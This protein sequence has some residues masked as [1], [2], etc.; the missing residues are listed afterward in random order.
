MAGPLSG[1]RVVDLTRALAGPYCSLLLGD[2]GADVIK[3]ELPGSGDETRQWGP[4]FVAGESSYFMSV[5]RNKRSATLDLKSADGVDVLKRLIQSADVLVENFRP[6]TMERLGLAYDDAHQLNPSL[7]YCSVSGFGQTGPRARQPAYDA[8]L[9]GMGGIQYLSGEAD[10]GPTRVGVPIADITAG[11]F[12]AYAVA[13]ALFWRERDPERRGQLID[14]SMLGGQVALLT[15]QAGRYFATDSAPSRIGN[16]HASIA[17]Y[18]MFR[19]ADGYVNV[20]AAN[21]PM[22]QRFCRALDLTAL[23]SDTRFGTNPDRVTN[24]AELSALIEAR[25][26]ELTQAEVIQRLEAAEVPVGP[27]YDLAQVFADPQSQ[28]LGMAVPTPHPKVPDLRTTG[29]P[30]RMSETNPEVRCPPPLLGEHTA[31]VLGELGYTGAEVER[32]TRPD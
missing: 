4:P 28:H 1:T 15:Y 11:M 26:M 29:F 12:A 10:G 16:R 23:L 18:E 2:M 27:V 22:W 9:Q 25:L 5:N 7:V 31:E 17:P 19:T 30:Y 3:I 21:E 14:T 20:A 24:R 13:S 8:I 6:G 32:L